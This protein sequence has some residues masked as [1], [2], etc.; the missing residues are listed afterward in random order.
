MLAVA[1]RTN[2]QLIAD[3]AQVGYLNREWRTLD[4]TYGAGVF[5]KLWRPRASKF[6]ACDLVPHKSPFGRPVDFRD[7]P[8]R[9]RSFRVVV[10]DPPYK[11]NGT[12]DEKIDE[13]YGVHI[14]TRWRD[15]MQLCRDGLVEACRVSRD[16]V[17]MKCQDQVCSGK[18]RWQTRDFADVAA[19]CGFGLRD[20][21]D[22]LSY[23]PQP[24][25]RRQVHARHNTS[26]LLV[27]QRGWDPDV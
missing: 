10:F 22:N 23:R 26:T 25:D 1:A 17:L 14:P 5:W 27:L 18:V 6:V 24:A 8:W 19:A 4:P 7:L 9:A 11:L 21:F 16:L 15:L 13:R 12:P 3:V 20:R 2:D